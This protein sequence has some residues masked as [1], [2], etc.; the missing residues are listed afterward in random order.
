M[1]LSYTNLITCFNG[2]ASALKAAAAAAAKDFRPK[3]TSLSVKKKQLSC[4]VHVLPEIFV[5]ST[6]KTRS[7]TECY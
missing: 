4:G 3:Q 1:A 2:V 7:E 5:N 6:K